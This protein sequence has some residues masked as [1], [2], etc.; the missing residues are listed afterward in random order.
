M[1]IH[2]TVYSRNS[3]YFQYGNS[4]KKYYYY[5]LQGRKTAYELARKQERAIHAS[6][7]KE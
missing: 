2:E 4:G 1:P 7:Y 3:G 5:T 6:G